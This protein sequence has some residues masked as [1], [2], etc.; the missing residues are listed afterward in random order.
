MN[1]F[2][3]FFLQHNF[4]KFHST[5]DNKKLFS[6]EDSILKGLPTDN[7]LFVPEHIPLL[8]KDFVSTLASK[9]NIEIAFAI[10]K[11]YVADEIS[12]AILLEIITDTLT[13]DIP[14]VLLHDNIF[15]L[16]LFHGPTLAFKDFGA[17]FMARII[18]YFLNKTKQEITILVAT[19]GDTGSAVAAGF[20]SMA[21]IHVVILYPKGRVSPLQEKQLTTFGDN[22]TALEIE[23]DFDQCQAIVKQLFLDEKLNEKISL[24]SAN[25]INIARLIPQMF[26]YAIAAKH[27]NENPIFCVPSGNFGNLTAGLILA[28]M[29]LPVSHFIA[30]CNANDTFYRYIETKNYSVKN[31]IATLS[32]AMDVSSPSNFARMQW[33]YDS[34]QKMKQK[35]A[36]YRSEDTDV[37]QC[38]TEVRNTYDY[39][40]DPHTAVGYHAAIQYKKECNTEQPLVILGT[41]HPIKFMEVLEKVN[42]NIDIPEA[43]LPIL[44]KEKKAITM[45]AHIDTIKKWLLEYHAI[46]V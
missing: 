11:K 21:G 23:G 41:A 28:E 29:G 22:I 9:T 16:E 17:R 2:I 13:F 1:Y 12:D 19:S 14:L 35:I 8:E 34:H 5:K 37:L 40:L 45:P 44:F 10:A 24:S 43:V 46:E 27:L 30:A 36:A 25:S 7:G 38:I 18:S 6:F 42:I 20:H 32:N 3:N 15:C 33:L 4:M 26:Y 39:I 31:T